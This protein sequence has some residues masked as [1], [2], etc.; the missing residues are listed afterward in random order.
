MPPLKE[1]ENKRK[2]RA[3]RWREFRE[4]F[5]LTQ[6]NLA[7]LLGFSRR[8]IQNVEAGR[9][10]PRKPILDLFE[11]LFKQKHAEKLAAQRKRKVVNA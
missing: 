3:K 4:E 10:T 6:W 2:A 5:M 8:Q 11:T 1:E 7:E 9:F